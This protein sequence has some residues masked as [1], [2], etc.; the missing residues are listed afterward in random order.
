MLEKLHGVTKKIV[1]GQDVAP[2]DR[3]GWRERYCADMRDRVLRGPE[4]YHAIPATY[5]L[6]IW[7]RDLQRAIGDLNLVPSRKLVNA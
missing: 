5:R 2:A 1:E 7:P 3:F 6:W 4:D